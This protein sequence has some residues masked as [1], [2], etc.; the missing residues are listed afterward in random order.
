[1]AGKWHRRAAHTRRG[2]N[3]QIIHVRASTVFTNPSSNTKV[4]KPA[5]RHECPECGAKIV[6]VN[7]KN[8]GWAHFEGGKGLGRIKHPCFDRGKG[9]SKRRDDNTADLFENDPEEPVDGQ[10]F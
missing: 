1:M 10:E 7:M 2:K 8:G 5:F 9:L 3:G 6:S 4:K